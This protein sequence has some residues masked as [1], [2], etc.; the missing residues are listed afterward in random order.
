MIVFRNLCRE[1]YVNL[2]AI[3]LVLLIIFITNQFVHYLKVA[4]LG[5]ITMLAVMKL[6]SLQIPLLLGY[7][8]PLGLYLSILLVLGRWYTENE[9]TVLS[10]CGVSWAKIFS[11]VFIFAFGV[12]I[13][14]G[15]LLLWVEPKVQGYRTQVLNE[16]ITRASVDKLIPS[17]FTPL[18]GAGVFY[19]QDVSRQ[20]E[21]MYNVFWARQEKSKKPVSIPSW[22]I[23]VARTAREQTLPNASGHF[24][25][26]SDGYRYIGAPGNAQMRVV[27]FKNY[28]I[29][30]A[31]TGGAKS[32]WP[33]NVP[34]MELWRL[35]KH[36]LQAAAILQWRFALPISVILFTLLAVPLSR[37]RPRQGKFA[38]FVPAI[39][40]YIGYAD[41]MFL[42][43]AW[44]QKG[45]ISP[46]LGLWWIHGLVLLIALYLIGR[47][48]SWRRVSALLLRRAHAYT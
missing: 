46:G 29:R 13:V 23:T 7:L 9:M 4:A 25:V 47:H 26:F 45:E 12:A 15:W 41:L 11:M 3:T 1:L 6:M 39:L 18:R 2:L 17:Q 19:A 21:K 28:G 44:I 20:A 27:Q 22:D 33:F 14:V 37:V 38:Q 40:I 8:L 36:N 42:G 43:R 30:L 5:Q 16:A 48:V 10:A 32:D 35:S 31:T 24:V 34:T